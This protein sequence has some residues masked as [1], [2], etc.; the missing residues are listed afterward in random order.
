ML[1]HD[2]V[3]G[4]QS[5]WHASDTQSPATQKLIIVIPRNIP[6]MSMFTHLNE[7]EPVKLINTDSIK[8]MEMCFPDFSTFC[9]TSSS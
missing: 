5:M 2:L 1:T 6:A 4:M 9:D 8:L 7:Q 3:D